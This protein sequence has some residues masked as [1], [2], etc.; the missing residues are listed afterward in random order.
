MMIF[1]VTQKQSFALS[2]GGIFFWN[3]FLG[4]RHGFFKWDLDISFCQISN[5]LFYWSKNELRKNLGKSLGKRY[6]VCYVFFG[7]SS[8]TSHTSKF[9]HIYMIT[10]D[11]FMVIVEPC[12]LGV[13]WKLLSTFLKKIIKMRISKYQLLFFS[14]YTYWLFHKVK[15]FWVTYR[16]Q[17]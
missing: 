4:L 5:L 10:Y 17:Q 2:S 11:N 16:C 15:N 7:I 1:E 3:I 8:N 9:W 6:D 12:E 13:S 14:R